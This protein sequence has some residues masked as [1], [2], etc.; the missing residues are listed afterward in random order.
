MMALPTTALISRMELEAAWLLA[1]MA[2]TRVRVGVR[3]TDRV[4]V[5]VTAVL[6]GGIDLRGVAY[7][8]DS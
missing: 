1:P 3:V 4:R 5:R 8:V 7:D 2:L 6:P